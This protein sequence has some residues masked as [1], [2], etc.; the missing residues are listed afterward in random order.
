MKGF[1]TLNHINT[2]SLCKNGPIMVTGH[3]GFKGAWLLHLLR[4]LD[5]P[6]VGF[7]LPPEPDCLYVRSKLEGQVPEHFGDIRDLSSLENFMHKHKPS[8][9]IHLAA[10]ALV[11]DSYKF[12]RETF[13]VN[14]IGT[15]NILSTSFACESVLGIVAATTDKVYQN[16]NSGR[17]FIESDPLAGKDPYS[18]SKVGAEAA[19]SAWQQI[20][21]ISG[22][23]GLV[24]V[25]AGNVIGG[26]DWAQ[27]RLLPDLIRGMMTG[28]KILI[29]NPEST[30]PWQHVLDP[31]IGYVMALSD[32]IAGGDSTSLNFGPN[33]PNLSV[34]QVANLAIRGWPSS[35]AQVVF[36]ENSA[37]DSKEA[38]HLDLN[39]DLAHKTLGWKPTWDQEKSVLDTV[40]WWKSI[41]GGGE[42]I[43]DA[44]NKDLSNLKITSLYL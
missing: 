39:A 38:A 24:S 31:L 3:T 29:R 15:T 32:S 11:T 6:A 33:G 36:D 2:S 10:Q 40:E 22:G 18:A 9:V 14:V 21:K 43:Q 42:S 16:D 37:K 7:S 26:G 35:A 1:D 20:K 41:L 17:K 5:I 19:I 28:D 27:N 12:P 34:A 13:E 30:R 44:I 25:R 8:G 4:Y 23:P